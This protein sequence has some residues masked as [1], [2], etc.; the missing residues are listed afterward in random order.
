MR[1]GNLTLPGVYVGVGVAFC[2]VGT[3]VI[4][5]KRWAANLAA[6]LGVLQILHLILLRATISIVG[7]LIM[8]A[9]LILLGRSGQ[10]FRAE[11]HDRQVSSEPAPSTP[12]ATS[13]SSGCGEPSNTRRS[14]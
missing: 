14:I 6:V 3:G 1:W 13:S 7:I 10:V 2:I 4:L 8:V 9:M 11:E 12:S 5:R